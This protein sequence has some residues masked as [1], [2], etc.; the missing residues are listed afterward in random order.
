MAP[1]WSGIGAVVPSCATPVAPTRGWLGATAAGAIAVPMGERSWRRWVRI[2]T[3][4]TS[5][6]TFS[7]VG[8]HRNPH[9]KWWG[10]S[11]THNS[12]RYLRLAMRK[13]NPHNGL[14]EYRPLEHPEYFDIRLEE[15]LKTYFSKTIT[16]IGLTEIN[17]EIIVAP[18]GILYIVLSRWFA[19]SVVL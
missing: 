12:C 9:Q 15:F 13:T 7:L 17:P 16:D 3:T 5:G 19:P 14:T 2:A 8:F 11:F 6:L 10:F 18:L 4:I 1:L